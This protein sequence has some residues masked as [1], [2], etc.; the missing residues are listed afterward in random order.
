[1]IPQFDTH[2]VRYKM[3]SIVLASA[4]FFAS[5]WSAFGKAYFYT[6]SELIQKAQ[7]IAIINVEEPAESPSSVQGH[8]PFEPVK[9]NWSYG[10]QAK[11]RVEQIL[12]GDAPKEFVLYGKETFICAQCS[13]SKGRFLAFLSKDG[14]LWIGANWQISLRPIRD[15]EV[16]WYVS[17][18]QR[19]PMNFQKLDEVVAAIRVA[20]KKQE[21]EQVVAPNRSLP[22]S[23]KS[24]SPV[25]GP[26]D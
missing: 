3:R 10:Q 16:E 12:K 8:D 24:T 1:M 23:Q 7:V 18:E 22:P 11:V 9:R 15:G 6:R 17:D 5:S 20:L 19:F 21:S 26:E 2:N 14:D 4:L 25:R 13:L